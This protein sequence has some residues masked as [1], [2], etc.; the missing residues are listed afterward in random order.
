MDISC[1]VRLEPDYL[2]GCIFIKPLT[3]LFLPRSLE[4]RLEPSRASIQLGSN[5]YGV[6]YGRKHD[7]TSLYAYLGSLGRDIGMDHVVD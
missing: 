2:L 5:T 1:H 4:D 7:C 6:C 3:L